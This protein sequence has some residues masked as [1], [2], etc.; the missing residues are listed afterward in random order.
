VLDAQPPLLAR[1]ADV[2]LT[3]KAEVLLPNLVELTIARGSM[4]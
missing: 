2:V 4:S 1:A 3:G